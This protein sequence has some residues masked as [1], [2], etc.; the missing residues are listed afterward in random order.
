MPRFHTS[1]FQ[2]AK[3][4]C[5]HKS[6]ISTAHFKFVTKSSILDYAAREQ[7]RHTLIPTPT[8]SSPLSTYLPTNQTTSPAMSSAIM[9]GVGVAT[10]AFLVHMHSQPK[11]DP[12]PHLTLTFSLPLH[13][14]EPASSHYGATALGS[15]PSAAPSTKAASNRA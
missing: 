3:A 7:D 2:Q 10:A 15:T 12:F 11:T 8:R 13:R 1:A 9:I 14:A 6:L 4:P 5:L